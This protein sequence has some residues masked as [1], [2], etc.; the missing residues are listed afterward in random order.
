MKRVLR[1]KEKKKSGQGNNKYDLKQI[2][3]KIWTTI[4]TIRL[5]GMLKKIEKTKS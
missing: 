2:T 4:D 1:L 3:V 5:E